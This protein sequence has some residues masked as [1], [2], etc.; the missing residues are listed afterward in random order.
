MTW[1]FV[2]FAAQLVIPSTP[3]EAPKPEPPKAVVEA[4]PKKLEYAGQPLVVPHECTEEQIHSLGLACTRDDP[5]PVFLDLSG[6]ELVGTTIVLTGNL[7]N[8]EVTYSSVLLVSEDLGKTWTEPLAR[9]KSGVLDQVQFVDFQNGW[10]AG[11]I[12][13]QQLPRDPFLLITN[14]G[15]RNWRKRPLYDDARL[16]SIEQFWFDTKSNGS[17]IVDRSRGGE[18]NAKYEYYESQTGGSS[19]TLRE[20]TSKP[21]QLKRSKPPV[22]NSD[23]R[24]RADAKLNAYRIERRQGTQWQTLASFSIALANCMPPE[25]K[26]IEPPPAEPEPAPAAPATPP[27]KRTAP[28]S[29]KK[30]PL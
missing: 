23:F 26:A 3:V 19:W 30:K 17:L 10:A 11:Q 5:C 4:T 7:H 21:V 1:L 25:Q 28:P 18:P 2:A 9:I 13:Q 16:G 22:V 8:R 15:G 24:V 20:V 29:L 27:A 12:M 14:D 6:H